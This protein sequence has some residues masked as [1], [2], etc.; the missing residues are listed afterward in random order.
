MDIQMPVMDGYEATRLIRADSRFATLPIIAMT[1]HAMLE[2]QQ[3]ILKSGMGAHIAKPIDV[4]TLLQVMRHFLGEPS[5]EMLL[6]DTSAGSDG[7]AAE[8]PVIPGFNVA[9]ALDRLDGNEKLYRWLLRSFVENKSDAVNVIDQALQSGD[10]AL[11]ER[12][13]HTIKSSAGTIGADELESL[14]QNLETAIECEESA[15]IISVALRHFSTEMERVVAVLAK[16]LPP[17]APDSD[18]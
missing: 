3:K 6:Q 17:A 5:G 8:I 10:T 7:G 12:T 15:E 9:A 16:T 14:A 18:T 4:R 2:E 11:A 13:A 1:A